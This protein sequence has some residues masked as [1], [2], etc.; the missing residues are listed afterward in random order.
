MIKKAATPWTFRIQRFAGNAGVHLLCGAVAVVCLFPIV[1]MLSSSLKTQA[2][3]FSDMSLIPT[4]PQFHNYIDA[5][6]QGNFGR[7]FFNSIWYTSCVVGGVVFFGSF[8]GS[9]FS[10]LDFPGKKFFFILLLATMMIPV[11]GSFVPLYVLL[12]KLHLIDTRLGYILPQINSGLPLAIFLFKTFFDKIPK[13]LEDSARVDGCSRFG[14]Y[15]NI[16]LPLARPAMAV[17]VIFTTLAAWNEYLLAYL[18]LSRQS[19]MPL[20]RG[21]M[22]FQGAHIT[23]YPLLM[24]GMMIS[25]VPVIVV[26]LLMHKHSIKGLMAGAVKT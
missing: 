8:A 14:I 25:I 16:A 6:T 3:V 12:N 11:P 23:Q 21:L 22:V 15:W 7:Y 17:V 24:A 10:R 20:Q 13:D 26:Y 4:Y 18:V 9:A 2:T 1:W 19:L 5:W